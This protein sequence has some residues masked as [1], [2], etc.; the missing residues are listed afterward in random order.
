MRD[1]NLEAYSIYIGK[2]GTTKRANSLPREA[3]IWA[4]KA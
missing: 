4:E 2:S 1:W 3:R